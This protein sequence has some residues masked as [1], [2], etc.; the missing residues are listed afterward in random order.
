[1]PITVA[2]EGG[3]VGLALL[4]WLVVAA[5]AATLLRLGVGFTSR[6]SLAIGVALVAITVHSLFYA[7]FFEDP[8]TWALLGL[9]GVVSLVPKKTGRQT[10]S[11]DAA[12]T[13]GAE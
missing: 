8:M 11:A 1:M 10:S 7:A 2:A 12:P 4:C 5:L 6:T 9:I 13:G 3:I